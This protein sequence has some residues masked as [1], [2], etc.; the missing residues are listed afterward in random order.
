VTSRA[1]A[2]DLAP[3][4][5]LDGRWTPPAALLRDVWSSRGLVLT[6]GRKNFFVQYRRASL[7]MTWAVALP[8]VQARC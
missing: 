5:F 3:E 4:L 7:G 2:G 1:A 8:L 6:L